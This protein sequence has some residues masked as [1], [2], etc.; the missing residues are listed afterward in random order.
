MLFARTPSMDLAA[1]CQHSPRIPGS[2]YSGLPRIF[3]AKLRESY[4]QYLLRSPLPTSVRKNGELQEIFTK[5]DNEWN[6]P[7]AKALS[8][9]FTEDSDFIDT[10]THRFHGRADIE[11]CGQARTRPGR[12]LSTVPG[13]VS[14][15]GGF[16]HSSF[17][18]TSSSIY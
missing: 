17:R 10:S 15:M 12:H 14:H 8:N 1:E 3:G 6:R 5:M 2:R 13:L 9:L 4:A 18:E 11:D 7:V 16:A